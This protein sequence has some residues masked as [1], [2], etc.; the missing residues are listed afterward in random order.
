LSRLRSPVPILVGFSHD[1]GQVT[2]HIAPD[3]DDERDRVIGNLDQAR[4]VVS[5]EQW[6]GIG[7]TLATLIVVP[8]VR[9]R[10][11]DLIRRGQ[12]FR[13]QPAGETAEAD[14]AGAARLD[15]GDARAA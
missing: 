11:R 8:A 9:R 7:P 15:T 2:H 6:P 3:V 14:D 1:T 12:A 4:M 10:P 5:I 13:W